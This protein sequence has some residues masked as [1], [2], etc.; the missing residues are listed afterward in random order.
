[1]ENTST[2]F[3]AVCN[4]WHSAL[5]ASR[6]GQSCTNTFLTL[7]KQL[8]FQTDSQVCSAYCVFQK[9]S[10]KLSES[11]YFRENVRENFLAK[12]CQN[13][14]PKKCFHK[15][16]PFVSHVVLRRNWRKS[17]L[18]WFFAYFRE[19]EK[20]I[21]FVSTTN[22]RAPPA[23]LQ[24]SLRQIPRWGVMEVQRPLATAVKIGK[25]ITRVESFAC[26]RRQ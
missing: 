3:F 15:N 23:V 21:F 19:N 18:F 22:S 16:G 20:A 6:L 12:N 1:M 13:L 26:H 25:Q 5:S 2:F 8:K 9:I 11:K 10:R 4:F 7:Q 14:M 24:T 17:Q